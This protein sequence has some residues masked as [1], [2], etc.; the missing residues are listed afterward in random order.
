[1]PDFTPPLDRGPRGA[2]PALRPMIGGLTGMLIGAGV[3]I[4]SGIFRTPGVVAQHARTPGMI[5]LAWTA[6]GVF[7]ILAGMLVAE[8]S[9]RFPRAGGEYNFLRHA[10]GDFVA[11]FF[12]WAYTFF[13]IGGGVA[14]MAVGLG[15][16]TCEAMGWSNASLAHWAIIDLCPAGLIGAAAITLITCINLMGLPIGAGTQNV[17]TVVKIMALLGVVAAAVVMGRAIDWT[18]TVAAPAAA[19]TQPAAWWKTLALVSAAMMPVMWCY[20]GTTDGVKMSEETRDAPRAIPFALISAGVLVMA[21]YLLLNWAFMR[22]LPIGK[23][24]ASPF[25]AADVLGEWLGARG[26]QVTLILSIGVVLGAISSTIVS[27][28]RVPFALARD[29]MT[30]RFIARMSPSQSPIGALVVG[31][32]CAVLFTL[33]GLY[34]RVLAMY[35]IASGVLFGLVNFSL[36]IFRMRDRRL[37]VAAR[38]AFRCPAGEAVSML[39]GLAQFAIAIG[40]SITEPEVAVYTAG[41]LAVIAVLYAIW[42][43]H[44]VIPR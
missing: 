40:V 12:G 35:T 10:Y 21:L 9:T 15:E 43:R 36:L 19:A 22:V 25:V 16:F 24:A 44:G 4:G 11:F 39:L 41:L 38:P 32:G 8:L 30:F 13:I 31:G 29:G 3:A 17:L 42:P 14:T 20:E 5:L 37:G 6:G 28:V 23:M 2:P 33:T 7:F 34:M 26:R 18:A 1:M 27:C